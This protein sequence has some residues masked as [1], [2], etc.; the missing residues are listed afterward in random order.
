MDKR[1]TYNEC[2]L[3]L[4][5]EGS[6]SSSPDLVIMG[7][8]VFLHFADQEFCKY[9]QDVD[10]QQMLVGGRGSW[11]FIFPQIHAHW[12]FWSSPSKLEAMKQFTNMNKDERT[13]DRDVC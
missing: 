7:L 9:E 13:N 3:G 4:G 10:L 8:G 6:L 5:V 1:K 2:L 11:Q 12:C